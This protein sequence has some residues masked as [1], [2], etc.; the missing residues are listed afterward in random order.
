MTTMGRALGFAF[1]LALATALIVRADPPERMHEG[2]GPR[3]YLVLRM[4]DDL[5]LSDEKALAVSRILKAGDE[6]REALHKKRDALEAKIRDALAQPKPDSGA[7][8]KLIDQAVD[9]H[10]E[11]SRIA[12]ESFTELKKVLTVE[13]Q[14]KLVLLRSRL[15]RDFRFHMRPDGPMGGEGRHHHH[16]R[17]DGPGPGPGPGPDGEH[18]PSPDD[19]P[20]A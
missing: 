20:E 10:K 11:Q 3:L 18:G 1:A 17:E 19:E 15:H 16:G 9:L 5:D 8:A 7:L 2:P 6:K 4:A 12:D 14:A 13:Q